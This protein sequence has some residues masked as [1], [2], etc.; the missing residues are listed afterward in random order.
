MPQTMVTHRR[1]GSRD[2]SGAE[3]LVPSRRTQVVCAVM[4][5]GLL[6]ASVVVVTALSD[7]I[8]D[9]GY[10]T[11]DPTSVAHAPWWFGVVS[12][13]ANLCWTVTATLN[14]LAALAATP[15]L[16]L[17]LLLLGV[18]CAALALDDTLLLHDA[19]LP[20]RGIA[21]GLVLTTYALAGIVAAWWWW[22]QRRTHVG[23]A[24]FI[25]A[26]MMAVS[27]ALDVVLGDLYVPEDGAKLLGVVAWG[28]CGAWGFSEALAHLRSRTA[29]V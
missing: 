2:V 12:R 24:F 25:G 20:G 9:T 28:F 10:L 22:P 11:R 6:M 5:V 19:V 17:P 14:I 23:I 1:R 15:P 16:R 18:L 13:L 3:V 29:D 26:V 7:R 21:E 8:P 27:V 4:V